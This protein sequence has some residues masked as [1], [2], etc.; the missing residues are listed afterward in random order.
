MRRAV[1]ATWM[2]VRQ[3]LASTQLPASAAFLDAGEKDAIRLFLQEKADLLLIDEI[4]GRAVARS[5]GL[6]ITGTIGILLEAKR[7]G[8]I[9]SLKQELDRLRARSNFYL[10]PVLYDASLRMAGETP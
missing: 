7:R 8:L 4:R 2:L 3:P 6:K 10:S 9:A 5:L 1:S